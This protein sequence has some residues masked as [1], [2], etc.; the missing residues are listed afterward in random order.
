MEGVVAYK[1][2]SLLLVQERV[3]ERGGLSR[4]SNTGGMC[5]ALMTVIVFMMIHDHGHHP[6]PAND[7]GRA[8]GHCP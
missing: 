1:P 2:R 4:W 7:S 5:L 8:R 3:L 6:H